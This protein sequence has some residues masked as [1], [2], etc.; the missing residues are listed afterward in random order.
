MIISQIVAM[1]KNRVIGVDGGLPWRLPDDMRWFRKV[2]MSKP[3]VMGRKTFDSIGKPLKGRTNI[4]MTRQCDFVAEGCIVVH[5]VED[6][7]AAA[8]DVAELVVIGGATIYDLFL[9][10]TD[11]IYLTEVAAEVDGDTWFGELSAENWQEIERV[12]HPADERHP[13][14]FSFVILTR[15]PQIANGE[16]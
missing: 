4:V 12:H 10:L 14:S 8:G 5:S 15:Q 6:A 1:D 11:K 16:N 7:I 3:I 9:P 13:Y 2:T